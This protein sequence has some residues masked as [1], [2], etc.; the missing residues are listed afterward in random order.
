MINIKSVPLEPGCY[1]FMDK[2]GSVIYVGKAKSLAN[3][4]SSYFQDKP[5]DPKTR[6]LVSSICSM[7][8]IVTGNE[9]EALI[10]ENTL[11]KKHKPKYN[12][13]LKDSQR[14]SYVL[15]T[16][17][18][19]PRILTARDKSLKGRYFG[20]FTSGMERRDL[21]EFLTRAFYIR[22]CNRLP[23]RP[24]LRFHIGSC[25]APCAGLV[26]ASEY[27]S[28][29]S[30]AIQILKG[31]N[32][33]LISELKS[34][35]KTASG[36]KDYESAILFRNQINAMEYLTERQNM[37]RAKSFDEDIINY[38]VSGPTVYLMVFNVSKGVLS[39]K[40]EF[41]FPFKEGFME[42]FIVQFYSKAAVP[43]E[44]ILPAAV[45]DS[46]KG[47]LAKVSG[48]NITITVPRIGDK[49]IL[50]D[51]VLKNIEV[52]FFGDSIKAEKL[53]DAV[54][55]GFLPNV[56]E[57]FDISHLGG[58][59]TVGSMVQFRSGRPDK[60]N[61]RRFKVR[62]A[63]DDTASISEVVYRRYLRLLNEKRAL[64][65]LIIIDGGIGQLN[66]AIKS[67]GRLSLKLPVVAIAKKFEEIYAPGLV[68]P[69]RLDRK[70]AGLRFI[71]EIRDEAHRFAIK[72]NR[73]LRSKSLGM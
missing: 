43:K 60:A 70:D 67:L 73:L 29:I 54:S 37:E 50:L 32:S 51:L 26:S 8:Y 46:V 20:P 56:I 30:R 9:V 58:T 19:F 57:C 47:Y 63:S 2:S 6:A 41:T 65:D 22:A 3:R 27:S 69:I 28:N 15:V 35:M 61:Y 53:R 4:V 33:A 44:L 16:E 71:Q 59:F 64:P 17:E 23:K 12:I 55:L 25:N 49:K 48:K 18:E 24:C 45:D 34:L 68:A 21:I 36:L 10:L 31:E 1:L 40:Q 14:Y 38:L 62:A 66:A 39:N 7:D 13:D 72:Y 5:R 11:I 42:E 52:S